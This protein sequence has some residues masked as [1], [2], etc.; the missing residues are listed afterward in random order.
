M[1]AEMH[2]YNSREEWLRARTSYIGGSDAACILG[3]NPWKSNQRLWEEKT[4]RAEPD[5]LSENKAVIYG[6]NAEEYLRKLFELDFPEMDVEYIENNMWTNPSVPWAHAS[7]DG[8]MTDQDG[9]RGILEI[10]TSTISSALAGEKWKGKKIPDNY[11][12][13]IVHYFLVTGFKF[14]IVKAQLKYER[15][16]EEPF[17]ITRHYRIEREDCE[18]DIQYLAAKERE[19]AEH[20]ERDIRPALILPEI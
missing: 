12:S 9:R 4:G 1:N 11:F 3:L 8:W 14:A 5:N 16:G 10:K 15:E 6:A 20:I 18:A 17:M 19:F 2:V 13:Q 7:L